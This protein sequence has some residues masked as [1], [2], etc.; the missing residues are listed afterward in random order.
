[1]DS[2]EK[3]VILRYLSGDLVENIDQNNE[4]EI[5]RYNMLAVLPELHRLGQQARVDIDGVW[6]KK[7]R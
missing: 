6:W 2:E 7:A 4:V 3:V 1:M 5:R